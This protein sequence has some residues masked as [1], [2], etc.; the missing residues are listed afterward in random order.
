MA[1]FSIRKGSK[2]APDGPPPPPGAPAP[3]TQPPAQPTAASQQPGT[4]PGTGAPT[5]GSNPALTGPEP[6][7]PERLEGQRAWIAQLDR[8]IGVRTYAGAAAL[9]IALAAAAVA[10]VLVLQLQDEAATTDDVTALEAQIEEVNDTAADAAQ[11]D[12]QDLSERLG[13]LETEVAEFTSGQ[14]STDQEISVIQ[15]D[16]QDLRDQIADLDQDSGGSSGDVADTGDIEN[17]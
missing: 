16:I 8:R 14:D 7:I 15:D 12:V 11:E 5:T 4:D 10:L 6:S 3:G 2:E 13:A 9:V 1:R 17:P